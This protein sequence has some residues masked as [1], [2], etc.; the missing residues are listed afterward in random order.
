[1]RFIPLTQ[2]QQAIVDD[3]D[4]DLVVQYKWHAKKG[5]NKFYA[6][7]SVGTYGKQLMHTL[8]TGFAQVDHVNGDGLDNTRA[9][10]R[11]ATT[12]Q[13]A[14][15]RQ[16]RSGRSSKYKG[17]VFRKD[18][19]K[20]IARIQVDGRRINIGLFENEMVAAKAYDDKAIQHFGEYAVLNFT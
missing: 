5:Y 20:W 19:K 8:I 1:M 2:G 6:G 13:N 17:V 11:P 3:E 10:L 12:S 4:Y 9:N 7:R 16:K 18:R 14:A 15:N